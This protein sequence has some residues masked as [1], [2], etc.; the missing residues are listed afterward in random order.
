MK[1]SPYITFFYGEH[2]K[3]KA[4][5]CVLIGNSKVKDGSQLHEVF[6]HDIEN[7][8]KKEYQ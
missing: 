5:T 8:T 6:R 7:D 1:A 3:P 4:Y 2:N